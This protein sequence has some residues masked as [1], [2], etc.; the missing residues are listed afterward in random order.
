M[1]LSV[2]RR[3]GEAQ[4]AKREMIPVDNDSASSRDDEGADE[5][6]DGRIEDRYQG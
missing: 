2:R 1:A 3:N 6:T 4:L 5:S